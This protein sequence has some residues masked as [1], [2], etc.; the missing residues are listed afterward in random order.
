MTKREFLTLIVAVLVVAACCIVIADQRAA[1]IQKELSQTN[2]HLKE[3]NSHLG[4]IA[5]D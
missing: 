4:K 3:L 2:Q 1:A 5:G